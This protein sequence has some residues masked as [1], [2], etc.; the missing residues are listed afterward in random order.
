MSLRTTIY[1][2]ETIRQDMSCLRQAS[3]EMR[4]RRLC[5]RKPS[6]RLNVPEEVH[7]Q[8]T[9]GGPAKEKLLEQLVQSGFNKDA[10]RFYALLCITIPTESQSAS[11]PGPTMPA[12][13]EI[14]LAKLTRTK[15]LTNTLRSRVRRGWFTVER[16]KSK[17]TWSKTGTQL[18][19]LMWA[20]SL[21][22]LC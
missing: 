21:S 20:A 19:L 12:L 3:K 14:F 16:M 1:D 13:Q 9:S 22:C 6:G 4:L 8:W 10:P 17:L 18:Q 2:L 5:E 11:S 15:T 7:K